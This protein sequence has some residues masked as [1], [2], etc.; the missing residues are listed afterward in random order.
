MAITIS[1]DNGDGVNGTDVVHY[2]DPIISV[3]EDSITS[4][5]RNGENITIFSMIVMGRFPIT[6]EI[7]KYLSYYYVIVN[8]LFIPL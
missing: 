3:L 1:N 2:I 8:R 6:D 7:G 4:S 5:G